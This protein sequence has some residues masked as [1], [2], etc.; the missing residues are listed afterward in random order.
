MR[1]STQETMLQECAHSLP[2]QTASITLFCG[3]NLRPCNPTVQRNHFPM[4]PS[5]TMPSVHNGKAILQNCSL[6]GLSRGARPICSQWPKKKRGFAKG[7]STP[8]ARGPDQYTADRPKELLTPML[9]SIV[10]RDDS[11]N[12]AGQCQ[13]HLRRPGINVRG[14]WGNAVPNR[15]FL[16]CGTNRRQWWHFLHCRQ[17]NG[18]DQ[19]SMDST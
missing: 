8:N 3:T 17:C 11:L 6:N 14:S 4:S 19:M 5:L 9:S 2:M 1:K 12:V 10:V 18:K 15:F 13:S 7:R 16:A